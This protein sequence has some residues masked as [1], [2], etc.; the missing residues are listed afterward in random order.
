MAVMQKWAMLLAGGMIGTA[1]R[2]LL[3]GAVHQWL[4]AGFPYGTLTVNTLGCFLAGFLSTLTD[5][6]FLLKPETR[7]FWMLG[8]L[9]AFTTFSSLIYESWRLLQD[10]EFALASANLLGSL[11]LGLF[12]LWAG[13]VA[14]SVL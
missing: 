9:G 3:G 10:G 14:A 4:G 8:L 13:H 5:Q 11:L 6:K 12:A 2:Y 1:G 7:V